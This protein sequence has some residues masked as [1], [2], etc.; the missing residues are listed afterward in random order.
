[1]ITLLSSFFIFMVS[2]WALTKLL[3][4]LASFSALVLVSPPMSSLYDNPYK[5]FAS[6]HDPKTIPFPLDELS[7][8]Q[9]PLHPYRNTRMMDS[10]LNIVL[11]LV[12][13]ERCYIKMSIHVLEHSLI[14]N[15]VFFHHLVV[16]YTDAKDNN[17][18]YL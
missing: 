2:V 5:G 18:S 12:S 10:L 16:V 17:L 14:A 7:Y 8:D 15:E 11:V 13:I 9:Q 1:M 6:Y 4:Y 3:S